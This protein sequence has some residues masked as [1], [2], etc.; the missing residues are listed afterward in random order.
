M[1]TA[2]EARK[3]LLDSVADATRHLGAA[4]TALGAAYEQLDEQRADELEEQLFR[5]VQLAYGRAQRTHADFA[6]RHGMTT[7][8]FEPPPP[9]LA[10]AGP[11]AFIESAV[12]EVGQADAKL[13]ELQD[14]LL[15]VEVGDA[16]LRAALADLR[17]LISGSSRRARDLVRVLGR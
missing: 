9:G 3:E 15:P 11:R 14:S 12:Q 2:S 7:R 1:Q 17:E 8:K 6:A 10:S 4:V 16:K 5:P 13:S